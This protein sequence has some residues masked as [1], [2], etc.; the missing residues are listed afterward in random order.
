MRRLI[1]F[2]LIAAAC[3][4]TAC[5]PKEPLTDAERAAAVAKLPAPFNGADIA[6]GKAVFNQCKSCHTIGADGANMT[7]PNLYNVW[8]RT[9]GTKEGF[10]Y[11]DAVKM[12]GFSWDA[13][14]LDRWLES[15]RGMMPGTKMSFVGLKSP[16][17]R[18]DV[19][20]YLRT[21][22]DQKP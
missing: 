15:P 22:S 19:I 13:E 9:A 11:S 7:G 4:V 17:D 12:A 16:Q 14:H 3:T 8:G 1:P 21:Q 10:N 18:V 6:N 5:K 2:A 20:G